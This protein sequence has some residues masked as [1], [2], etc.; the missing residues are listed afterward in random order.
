MRG[1]ASHNVAIASVLVVTGLAAGAWAFWGYLVVDPQRG[2]RTPQVNPFES[3]G[4]NPQGYPEFRHRSSGIVFVSLPGGTFLMG[5]PEGEEG[6]GAKEGPLHEVTL[7]PFMI[8]KYEVTQK[9]WTDVMG[10]FAEQFDF[11]GDNRPAR[12]GWNHI[13]D[14]EA[15]T[16]LGLPTEAQWEYACRAGTLGPY[17]GTGNLDDMGWHKGNSGGQTH[18]VGLKQPNQ[19]G[20]FDMHG[21]AFEWCEDIF[22]WNFYKEPKARALNPVATA[23][24]ERRVVRGGSYYYYPGACRSA[25]RSGYPPSF[26]RVG[27]RTAAPTPRSAARVDE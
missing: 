16:G 7:S 19:F 21:N 3:L 26:M 24:S 27:F 4:T 5:S 18:P 8:A 10:P 14:F 13:Q 11:P 22:D 15:V 6:R 20:L 1:P 2:N 17:A 12:V 25:L 9:Q 23:G